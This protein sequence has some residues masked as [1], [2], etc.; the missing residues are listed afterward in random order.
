MQTPLLDRDHESDLGRRW[1]ER[2]D[3]TALHELITSHVRLVVRIAAGFRGYGLP[4][5]DLI[6]EGNVGLLEAAARFDPDRN[7]RF[8][9]YATWWILAAI[10]DY[11]VRNASIVRIGTTP[12]Q[13]SLFFNLRRLRARLGELSGAMSDEH[14]R[15]VAKELNVPLAAVD[16][17]EAH[18]AAPDRS[19]N[20]GVGG[21]DTD[22]LQDNNADEG[23]SPEEI[24]IGSHDSA[25]RA[26]WLRE[27]MATLTPRERDIIRHRFLDDDGKTTLAEIGETYGV[28]KERIRQIEGRALSKLKA[29]LTAQHGRNGMLSAS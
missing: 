24:V 20:A 27:A 18:L 1:R 12:S 28:T 25:L 23:P 11:I 14:R 9:T 13:K 26:R 21:V 15:I 17:M 16:R 10:Q 4:L 29:T 3:E 6:Q 19:L 7:V 22:E 8:S 5:G 2:H